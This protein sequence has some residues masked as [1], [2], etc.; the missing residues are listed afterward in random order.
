MAARRLTA[1]SRPGRHRSAR[2]RA[3]VVL[4][5]AAGL[6]A[7]ASISAAAITGGESNRESGDCTAGRRLQVAAAPEL[8]PAVEAIASSSAGLAC[9]R[10][11][12]TPTRP[13]QVASALARGEPTADVWIPDSSRWLASG[14]PDSTAGVVLDHVASS[15][16][17]LAVTMSTARRLGMPGPT[18]GSPRRRQPSIPSPSAPRRPVTRRRP[19]PRCSISTRPW[20]S[21]RRSGDSSRRCFARW[22]PGQRQ[23]A[24]S[25]SM[26]ACPPQAK[27]PGRLCHHRAR[28]PG[29]ER[30]GRSSGLSGCPPT[31]HRAPRWTTRTSC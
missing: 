15:P 17:V 29:R 2:K 8:V 7:A 25:L 13:A 6:F 10:I 19:R 28:S 24:V 26:H 5:A 14:S 18:S 4:T 1:A 21:R 27:L 11:S 20:T 31:R 22:T 23:P 16:V 9:L 30:R 12:V 3:A